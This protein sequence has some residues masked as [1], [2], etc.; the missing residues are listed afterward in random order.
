M[1]Q[2]LLIAFLLTLISTPLLA[3][4]KQEDKIPESVMRRVVDRVVRYYFKPHREP[5]KIYISERNIKEKW[6]PKIRNIEFVILKDDQLEDKPKGYIFREV[7]RGD[8]YSF[9]F[10]FGDLTPGGYLSGSVWFAE[11]TK[12]GLNISRKSGGW[13]TG[14]E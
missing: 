10:G 2:F 6:L 11:P 5:K 14:R 4:T 7:N 13:S 3:Q 9:L 8:R 1:K 12:R